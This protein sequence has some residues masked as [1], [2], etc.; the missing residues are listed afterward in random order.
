MRKEDVFALTSNRSSVNPEQRLPFPHFTDKEREMTRYVG[1]DLAKRSMQ[2]CAVTEES[3]AI[4]RRGLKTDEKGR[5]MLCSFLRK[6]DVSIYSTPAGWR[7]Y[8]RAGRRRTKKM[9]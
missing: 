2:V 3:A 8:G 7:W 6:E 1:T 9:P 4:E 5:Q